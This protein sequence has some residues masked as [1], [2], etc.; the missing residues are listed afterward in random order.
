MYSADPDR[1]PDLLLVGSRKM[2]DSRVMDAGTGKQVDD[3]T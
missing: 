1:K 2:R 3:K